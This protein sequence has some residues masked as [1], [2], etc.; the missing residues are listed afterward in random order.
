LAADFVANEW[1]I[2]R[3]HRIIVLSHIYRLGSSANAAASSTYPD[4]LLLR[5]WRTRRLEAEVFRDSV[6]AVSGQPG[7]RRGGPPFPDPADGFEEVAFQKLISVQ[8]SAGGSMAPADL[9]LY[10]PDQP[11]YR[12]A[13]G[14]N[15]KWK[16]FLFF[17]GAS[18]T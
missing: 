4:N 14:S 15:E 3:L 17:G 18:A 9:D 13:L 8:T 1:T 7:L 16:S 12:G 6:L 2:K 10:E 5:R 11:N